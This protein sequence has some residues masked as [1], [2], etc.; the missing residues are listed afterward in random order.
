MK[1]PLWKRLLSYLFEWHIESAP[2]EINPHLYV[3]LRSGRYQLSTANAVYSYEDLYTNYL[4][5]FEHVNLDALPNEEALVLGLGLGS[6]PL[7]LEKKFHKQ[8]H[9]T[10]VE[11][12]EAVVYLAGRYGLD[13]LSSPIDTACADAYA[14]MLQ[15]EKQYGLI[16]MDIFLDDVVPRP[17]E[18][19]EF[20]EALKSA[21]SPGGLLLYNRLADNDKDRRATQYFFERHFLSVFPHGAYLDVGGNWMLVNHRQALKG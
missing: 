3:S 13:G 9:Y 17:F 6:I 7:I 10:A 5:A 18:S 2:S 20:L 1:Q 21:L 16:C 8:F 11:L 14:F 19:R 12:D 15:N 4:W